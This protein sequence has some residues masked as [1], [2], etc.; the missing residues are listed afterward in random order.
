MSAAGTSP[1]RRTR[2]ARWLGLDQ[3]P[4]RRRADRLEVTLRLLILILILAG[5]PLAWPSLT[6]AGAQEKPRRRCA[7]ASRTVTGGDGPVA[8]MLTAGCHPGQRPRWRAAGP[9]PG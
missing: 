7:A 8:A 1:A 3:N 6:D 5:V 2:Y 4:L 9:G